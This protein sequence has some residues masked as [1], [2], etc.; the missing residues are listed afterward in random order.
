M[1]TP[2]AELPPSKHEALQDAATRMDWTAFRDLLREV[3]DAQEKYAQASV[4]EDN[5][6]TNYSGD[7][8]KYSRETVSAL[9]RVSKAEKAARDALKAALPQEPAAR[10]LFDPEFPSEGYVTD[11]EWDARKAAAPSLK[12]DVAE[13][14]AELERRQAKIMALKREALAA[15][16]DAQ[17]F[18]LPFVEAKKRILEMPES[19]VRGLAISLLIQA[20]AA[21]AGSGATSDQPQGETDR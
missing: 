15:P 12:A 5:A 20:N 19:D 4:A 1:T 21:M 13:M 14:E 10:P 17:V 18:G 8:E 11:A 9:E 6:T 7:T 16:L 3:L 2:Q